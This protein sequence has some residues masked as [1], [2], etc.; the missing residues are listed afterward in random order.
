MIWSR[1]VDFFY[2]LVVTAGALK[3]LGLLDLK[4]MDTEIFK[5]EQAYRARTRL[6]G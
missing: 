3:R 2:A 5:I 1:Q 6:L 4:E